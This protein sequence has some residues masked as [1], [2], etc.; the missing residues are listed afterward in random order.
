MLP[1][2]CGLHWNALHKTKQLKNAKK[3]DER[4]QRQRWKKTA[5]GFKRAWIA[6][7]LAVILPTNDSILAVGTKDGLYISKD[8][9]NHFEKIAEMNVTSLSYGEERELF[10]GI[11]NENGELYRVDIDLKQLTKVNLPD[12]SDDAITYIA[13]NPINRNELVFSTVKMNI[14]LSAELIEERTGLKL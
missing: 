12:L 11:F 5:N 4:E 8:A 6:S 10:V 3:Q 1:L 2:I 14:Y 7:L 13:Q 9:G